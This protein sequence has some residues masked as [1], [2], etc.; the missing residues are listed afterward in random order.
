MVRDEVQLAVRWAAEEG[1]NPGIHDAEAFYGA[2]PNGFYAAERGGEIVG[3]ASLVSYPGDLSFAGFLIVRPDLRGQGIGGLLIRHLMESGR[4]RNIGGDGVPEMLPTYLRK[5][6]RFAYWHRRF[7][8]VGGGQAAGNLVALADLPFE[9]LM[10]YDRGVF[11]AT[12]DEFLRA[13]LGAGGDDRARLDRG[14]HDQRLWS[15]PPLPGRIQ[16]RPLVRRRPGRGGEGPARPGR[17]RA[18]G[19]STSWTSRSPTSRG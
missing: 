15:D 16:D 10:R 3:T 6:F 7:Q 13:F 5:G 19:R 18:G 14:R 17:H 1:W 9:E 4:G 12:R 8:G 2:D 11:P